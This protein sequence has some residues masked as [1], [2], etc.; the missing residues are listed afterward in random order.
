MD[1]LINTSRY[2][3]NQ[4]G[5]DNRYQIIDTVLQLNK[6]RKVGRLVDS[7]IDNNNYSYYETNPCFEFCQKRIN[8]KTFRPIAGN[9]IV[10]V[11]LQSQLKPS[12]G[13]EIKG[14]P[15]EQL[16]SGLYTTDYIMNEKSEDFMP[17]MRFRLLQPYSEKLYFSFLALVLVCLHIMN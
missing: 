13:L 3:E 15:K 8:S 5:I 10:A 11:F 12:L 2:G 4:P 17:G 7:E 6:N 16:G 9:L 1:S 14:P